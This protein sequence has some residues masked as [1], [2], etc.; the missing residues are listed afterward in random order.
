MTDFSLKL[1][2]YLD[3]ELDLT[4]AALVEARL[5]TDVDARSELDALMQADALA[6]EQFE[7]LLNDPVPF[8]LAQQIKAAKP[9]A[10]PA[11][12]RP[13][14]GALAASLVVFALGGVGGY[15]F[16]GETAP[17]QT[18]GWLAS[19]A[20]YHVVYAAQGRH[21]VEVGADEA[22]HIEAW[23]GDTVGAS[24]SI[25]DL[26]GFGLTFEGGRLLVAN[27]KPVAQ[28]MYRQADG[29][30][31]A[32]CLQRSNGPADGAPVFKE[33]TING[34]DFVSWNEGDANYVVIGPEGQ[35]DL[36]AIAT[37]AALEI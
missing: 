35:P 7:A 24:F 23:L 16:K 37:T 18:A 3:G 8:A 13:I 20:E 10:S 11:P 5:A 25:P 14:W 31:V 6:Q 29:T 28:L 1:S 33:Q 27:G 32:L 2:A 30:V 15:M 9:N 21:L 12:A 4:D 22:D 36:G 19:I 34:F 17:V 26:S